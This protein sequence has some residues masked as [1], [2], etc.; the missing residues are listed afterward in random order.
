MSIWSY[1]NPI[2]GRLTERFHYGMIHYRH[3]S[4]WC[5]HNVLDLQSN[6]ISDRSPELLTELWV[7][8]LTRDS[9][10]K[11]TISVL[12]QQQSALAHRSFRQASLNALRVGLT[13]QEE[14][15]SLPPE[16]A[17]ARK[18]HRD[19]ACFSRRPSTDMHFVIKQQGTYGNCSQRKS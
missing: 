16:C 4:D 17:L 12:I 19:I 2:P 3:R 1:S 6:R 7:A 9:T 18:P 10:F 11:P 13:W 15:P 5:S 14:R 8:S